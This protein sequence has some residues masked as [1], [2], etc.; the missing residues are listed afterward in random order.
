MRWLSIRA[1]GDVAFDGGLCFVGEALAG[2]AAGG[3]AGDG[4]GDGGVGGGHGLFVF[5]SAV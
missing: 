5:W 1:Y 4:V 3:V 2:L